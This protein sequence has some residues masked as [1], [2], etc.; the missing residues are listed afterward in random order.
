M[1]TE[2]NL[3]LGK[4]GGYIPSSLGGRS[5]QAG[6]E[7]KFLQFYNFTSVNSKA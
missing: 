5:G 4:N 7:T 6:S 2:I 1:Q 3:A